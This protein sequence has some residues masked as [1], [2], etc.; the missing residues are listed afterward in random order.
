M[1]QKDAQGYEIKD[2]SWFNGLSTDPGNSLA[3]PRAVP[4]VV[5]EFAERVRAGAEVNFADVI[6]M[7]D[8]HYNYFAVSFTN[9][10]IVNKANENT[11][12][13]KIFSFGLMTRMDEATT[14]R[15]FGEIYRDLKR[16]Y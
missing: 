13:A 12:S 7:L 14:L 5:K 1:A 11:G 3:D 2:R 10:N 4:P 8:E 16:K 9:G 15:M 6:K